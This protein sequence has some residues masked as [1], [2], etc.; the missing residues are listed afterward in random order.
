MRNLKFIISLILFTGIC[1]SSKATNLTANIA[2]VDITPPLEMNY[3]LGGYGERMNAPAEGIHDRIWAKALAF[4]NENQKYV[5][6][7]LDILG[8]P[9]NIKSDLLERIK[10]QGW[11]MENVMLLPSHSH[12]S[13]EMAALNSKNLLNSPQIGIFQPELLEFILDKLEAV[14]IEADQNYL[15]VKVGTESKK[16]DGLNRNRRGDPNVDNELT[17]TRVNLNNGIP[18]AVLVNWTAHPTFI[19]GEDMLVSGEWP[20]YLQ[21]DLQNLIGKGVTAMYYNGAEGDQSPILNLQASAYEKVEVYGKKV[22]LEAFNIYKEIKSKKVKT[23]QFS[24]NT[25][26]LP[27]HKAHPTFMETGGEEYGLDENTVK[28]VM[29]ML[30]PTEVGL[31]ALRIDDLIIAGVPGEMTAE[32][33]IKVKESIKNKSIKFV[34]IGGLANEWISY[35]LTRYQYVNGEGYESSVSFYGPDLG[36]IISTEVIKTAKSITN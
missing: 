1:M 24:Y 27:E 21:S 15:P 22:A 17:V 29:N 23:F 13:L 28:L 5:I 35:I 36:E 2:S 25:I 34:A 18:L 19:G 30:G 32:L 14:I 6:I 7:T 33:G 20:G 12:G 10:S 9:S 16:I 26:Q 31:G 3:T 8:L 11:N 4:Q